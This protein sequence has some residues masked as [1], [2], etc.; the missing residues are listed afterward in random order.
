MTVFFGR[1][2]GA[3]F[4]MHD[5]QKL[6]GLFQRLHNQQEFAGNGVGLATVER[7]VSRDGGRIWAE[8]RSGRGATF[9]FTLPAPSR[10]SVPQ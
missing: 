7:I 5:A 10:R 3:G 6:F 8:G 4:D 2:N 9:H 1:D